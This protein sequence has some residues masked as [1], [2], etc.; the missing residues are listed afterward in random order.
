MDLIKNFEVQG[1]FP[2]IEN[3][4][5]ERMFFRAGEIVVEN[6]SSYADFFTMFN[7]ARER[8]DYQAI[9]LRFTPPNYIEMEDKYTSNLVVILLNVPDDLPIP[10]GGFWFTDLEET[11]KT[12]TEWLT[13]AQAQFS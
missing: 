10:I 2:F 5:G 9:T 6:E 8:L 1:G 4:K 7:H 3:D 12:S 13:A 11:L